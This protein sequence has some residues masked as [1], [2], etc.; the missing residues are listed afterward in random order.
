MK[1]IVPPCP[2]FLNWRVLGGPTSVE[3]VAPE[4]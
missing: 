3:H 1:D 4:L 2:Q